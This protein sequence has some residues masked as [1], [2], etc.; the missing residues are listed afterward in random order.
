MERSIKNLR[1]L[2]GKYTKESEPASI[3]INLDKFPKIDMIITNNNGKSWGFFSDS[4]KCTY[5]GMNNQKMYGM[6][7]SNETF[8]LDEV[9]HV[10]VISKNPELKRVYEET[11][12]GLLASLREEPYFSI[13][14]RSY[15]YTS[16]SVSDYKAKLNTILTTNPLLFLK[17]ADIFRPVKE[18]SLHQLLHWMLRNIP[19]NTRL[20]AISAKE[21]IPHASCK[22]IRTWFKTD[23]NREYVSKLINYNYSPEEIEEYRFILNR[24]F[25]IDNEY[26]FSNKKCIIFLNELYKEY[27]SPLPQSRRDD[28]RYYLDY[29]QTYVQLPNDL[30]KD[31]PLIPQRENIKKYHDRITLVYEHHRQAIWELENKELSDKY[32]ENYYPKAKKLE[33]EDD[34]YSI[35][36]CPKLSDLTIEGQ[37]L[38]HCV[39]TYINSVSNGYEYILFLRK[40]EQLDTPFFTIDVTPELKV[41]QIHGAY[42]CNMSKELIP[43][44]DS[45]AK[46]FKLDISNCS[47]IHCALN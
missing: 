4:G 15:F 30:K 34:N 1:T 14:G 27:G 21:L 11:V 44:V 45:W 3:V 38:H 5:I 24:W 13:Y 23:F 17:F 40:K 35:I 25:I 9:K 42:N 26:I 36:A 20:T 8:S 28:Y 43:F 33:F 2:K 32:L 16:Y 18:I 19:K 7:V 12:N 39:G 46:K 6:L 41:R 31:F 22:Y 10:S 37:V 29:L 47:G